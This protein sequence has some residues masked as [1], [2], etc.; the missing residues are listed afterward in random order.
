LFPVE[1]RVDSPQ[2]ALASGFVAKVLIFPSTAR[3]STLT[4]VPVS[5]IVEGDGHRASVYVVDGDH[6]KRR[7]VRVAFIEA[8]GVAL[9][10]GL[11]PGERVVTDGALYLQD[12]ER[13]AIVQDPTKVVGT[14][15]LGGA[16]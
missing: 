9:S 4:Y 15:S 2:I 5:A 8:A 6:A 12:N 13:I 10:E 7:D 11:R 16:G 3:A 14:V 1:I